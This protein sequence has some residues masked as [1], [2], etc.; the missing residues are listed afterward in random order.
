MNKKILITLGILVIAVVLLTGCI[1]KAET[2][3]TPTTVSTEC[4]NGICENAEDE[5]SCQQDC[6][7]PCAGASLIYKAK[8]NEL[9]SWLDQRLVDW[10]PKEYKPMNFGVY[11]VY[12]SDNIFIKTNAD[13][14]I[15]MLDAIEGVNPDTVVLYI[16]PGSYFSQK[17]RYDA[18]IGKIRKDGKKLFIGA[19]PDDGPMTFEQYDKFLTNYTKNIIAVI[20]PDYY[21]IIL[22]PT[23]MEKWH[24]FD[25]TDEQWVV[26]VDRTAKL[27]KQLSPA[28]KTV[29]DGHK[30]ELN[31]LRLSS[32][33]R[34]V[35][36]IAFN[37]YGTEGIYTKYSG[38]LGK[39]DVVGNAID[40]TNSKGKETW[41]LETWT[42][43]NIGAF[44]TAMSVQE[45]MKPIDAKWVRVM[46]YYAQ[47]H[48]MKAIVPFYT[49]KF[50]YYGTD[51]KEFQSALNAGSRMPIFYEYKDVISESKGKEGKTQQLQMVNKTKAME[52]LSQVKVVSQ[53]RYVTDGI[54]LGRGLDEVAKIFRETKTDFIFQ[55]WLTQWPCPERCSDLTSKGDKSKCELAGYSYEHL[56]EAVRK[57]KE[58]MPGVIFCGGTQAEF[59]YPDDV[60]GRDEKE[61]RDKTWAMTLDPSKWGVNMSR[62][63]MQC[64]WARRW[65]MADRKKE[66]PTEE[67]LKAMMRHYFPDL[68]NPELQEIFLNRI[69]K[70]IDSGADAIWIDMLYAQPYLL[71]LLTGDENHTAVQ[72]SYKSTSEIV[73]RIHEYGLKKDKHIYVIT[74]VLIEENNSLMLL[75]PNPNVDIAMTS[76][77]PDEILDK[78]SGK[79]GQFKKDRLD[80]GAEIIKSKLGIPVFARIDYGGTG[81]SPLKVFS[82]ELTPENQRRFLE[83]ADRFYSDRGIY[84]IY[85][86][87]GGDMG[88]AKEVKKLSYGKY[89]W[90]DALAPEFNTYETIKELAQNKS[91]GE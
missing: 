25:A 33:L 61:R 4:G 50:V 82:Q 17:E 14:D 10:K 41:M 43:A 91:K 51:P 56:R 70:Q 60:S 15:K 79:L 53:Y 37:I 36:I 24:N 38:Y 47:R 29:A 62:R 57:I 8:C 32:D 73:D 63:D 80:R 69:Y 23:T 58:E 88:P 66:C 49:G 78:K 45:F 13:V 11:H 19:R 75:H 2:T 16:R 26:L 55:G 35:D 48:N 87:H 34:S 76:P 5:K 83:I 90:Y 20:K 74:W 39:G 1:R 77:D 21:G 65:G 28:T 9:N 85:P 68:T 89:N 31:F 7:N 84:F 72:D 64:Y 46:T 40:S 81:R 52:K 30:E 6:S 71:K 54:A 3:T 22:E 44:Q 59:L 27:S 42:S 12:A 18:L 67:E 86:I